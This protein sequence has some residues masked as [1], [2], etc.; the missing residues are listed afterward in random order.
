M[1]LGLAILTALMAMPASAQ[2]FTTAGEVRPILTATRAN[3]I[4]LRRYEGQD[5]LYFTQLESWRCGLSE[6]R[7][8]INGGREQVWPLE[9]C[10]EGTPTPNAIQGNNGLP[11]TALPLDSVNQVTVTVIYDD[12]SEDSARFER[13]A[14]LIP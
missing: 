9:T 6:V 8:S 14:I 4:A 1:R 13:Q 10:Y 3:W 5:L 11:Y 7:F 12:G 2:Q